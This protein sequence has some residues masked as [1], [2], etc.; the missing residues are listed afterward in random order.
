MSLAF[1]IAPYARMGM[2]CC[3]VVPARGTE[4]R[5]GHPVA[6][7]H[8]PEAMVMGPRLHGDDVPLCGLHLGTIGQA[9]RFE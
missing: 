5:S 3:V 8:I 2:F 6:G 1:R 9:R 4:R 7:I